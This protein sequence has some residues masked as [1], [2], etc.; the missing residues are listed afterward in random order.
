MSWQT[1]QARTVCTFIAATVPMESAGAVNEL[2]EAAKTIGLDAR[3]DEEKDTA[4]A[5]KGE[6]AVGTYEK[7]MMS[8]GA[9]QR[10]AGR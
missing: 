8:F 10:W 6:P 2:L 1:W 5:V 4:P 7:F 9:P 3:T